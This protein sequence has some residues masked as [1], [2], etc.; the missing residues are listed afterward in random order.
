MV[1]SH[2]AGF[3][4]SLLCFDCDDGQN[5]S[6]NNRRTRIVSIVMYPLTVLGWNI[7]R[8]SLV[9]YQHLRYFLLILLE[10]VREHATS[11]LY[12]VSLI[13]C[14][15]SACSIGNPI[16]HSPYSFIT[17]Y[18]FS[19]QIFF[20]RRSILGKFFPCS[21]LNCDGIF[22]PDW[23]LNKLQINKNKNTFAS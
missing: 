3:F 15:P 10:S 17:K 13:W 8:F 20:K 16:V 1:Q 19:K 23:L 22:I 4:F 9:L 7:W 18:L 6:K 21:T 12:K 2:F 5:N 11:I 14:F